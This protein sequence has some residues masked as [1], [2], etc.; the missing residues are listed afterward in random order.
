MSNEENSIKVHN[1]NE[2]EI[3]FLTKINFLLKWKVHF[4]S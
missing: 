2:T 3:A 1:Q 4:I